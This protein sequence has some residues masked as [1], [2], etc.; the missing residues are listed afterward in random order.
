MSVK[1]SSTI[2][3]YPERSEARK[4]WYD[5]LETYASSLV[6][7]RFRIR[8]Q[9]F[10]KMVDC[11]NNLGP[12]YAALSLEELREKSGM[13]AR[14]MR[15]DGYKKEMVA[16]SFAMVREISDRILGMRH[17]DVQLIGG[18][19]LLGG[20][21]AEMETGEGKTL[22]ATLP[23]CTAAL[24]GIPVHVVTV[25]DY[26]AERDANWM[27]PIYEAMGLRVGIIKHGLDPE[28]RRE[29]YRCDVT[30]CTNK[31]VAFDYLKDRITLWDRPS[32]LRLQLERLSGRNSRVS[33]L[34]M[35]GLHYAIVDEADS[36]L[37]DEARTPLIISE[38]NDATAE[39]SLYRQAMEIAGNLEQQ[40]DFKI[41]E[42][43]RFVE[44]T[45]QGKKKI[46]AFPWQ[47]E[48][49]GTN[50]EQRI[51]LVK[52]AL[53]ALYIFTLDKHYLVNEGKVQ[54]VDEY[55]GRVMADRSWERGLHQL[56]EIKENC[57][58]TSRK[59]TRARI[60]YQRFFRRYR[61]L[62]GM[63]G[64]AREIKTELWS[65]YRLRV[66]TVPTNRTLQ[67]KYHANRFFVTA[68]EKWENVVETISNMHHAGR[69][70]LIGTRSVAASEHLSSLLD[71]A[72]LQHRVLN[73][74]QDHEEAE[75]IALA[76]GSGR[77]T[78][79]TNMAGRGTDI[80]LNPEVI[81]LGGLHVIATE[82]H[83]ARRIDRQLFGRCARQGEPG[84][85]EAI[86]SLEDELI[87]VNVGKLPQKLMAALL[88]YS[89]KIF[90]VRLILENIFSSAQRKAEKLHAHMR[91]D[92]LKMDEQIGDALAF[93]GRQ[94]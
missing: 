60:S 38:A 77:I 26:L 33:R 14:E 73:A 39:E 20:M 62:A 2:D 28:A 57:E 19:V 7:P 70:V 6:V 42:G 64:T 81:E 84:S 72:S 53:T 90:F 8:P 74:R 50:V 25:N 65:I 45:E 12:S 59:A 92:L 88:K 47:N 23:A 93:S 31:E 4:K 52:Q 32:Q 15:R 35:R 43:E 17:F 58:V 22:V 9:S 91:R 18:L 5:R 87:S 86:V 24:A 83:E 10:Q 13:L 27:R 71:K 56:I 66:V 29:A 46:K 69:P 21:I 89:G 41:E 94:E 1:A 63:T 37:V 48:C 54:I 67:R 85:C 30:Y 11:I 55:T 75:I 49:M 3:I 36:V 82:R 76:G 80:R 34:L 68:E 16:E 44:I 40:A 79:A 61:Q 78:V 51:E